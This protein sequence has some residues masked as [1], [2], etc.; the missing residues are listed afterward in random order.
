MPRYTIPYW[1]KN[2]NF[3][4]EISPYS[5]DK[6]FLE[7]ILK[8][9]EFTL[10]WHGR[11][12][13]ALVSG[14]SFERTTSSKE[15]GF[16]SLCHQKF[17]LLYVI[18]LLYDSVGFLV[19]SFSHEDDISVFRLSKKT[20][21][22]VSVEG[23]SNSYL[24]KEKRWNCWRYRPIEWLIMIEQNPTHQLMYI[25]RFLLSVAYATTAAS[26]Q[27]SKKLPNPEPWGIPTQALSGLQ[28][29]VVQKLQRA[30][31]GLFM[32]LHSRYV[33]W[34]DSAL[35]LGAQK[36]LLSLCLYNYFYGAWL[37]QAKNHLTEKI[38]FCRCFSG[39]LLLIKASRIILAE[40][41][42]RS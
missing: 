16:E 18:C 36:A 17:Y 21:K 6:Y 11:V 20:C 4:S 39:T 29:W 42:G 28:Q 5:Q 9:F 30:S 1:V 37:Y 13:M 7:Y 24:L 27:K 38:M 14:S 25:W 34:D 26:L 23:A 8:L 41:H 2:E 40:R 33:F 35:P 10:R 15:R 32:E 19:V 12:V 22:V 3:S 31:V